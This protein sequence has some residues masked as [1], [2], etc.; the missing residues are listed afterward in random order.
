[1]N[2]SIK[3]EEIISF[4]NKLDIN[5]ELVN[6]DIYGFSRTI[7]FKVYDIIYRIVW[8][9]NQSTLQ[10]GEGKRPAQIPFRFI[11]LDNNFP[12]IGENKSIGFSYNKYEKKSMFGREYPYEV[13][14]IP[15]D[16]NKPI[17]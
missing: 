13:F 6:T 15:L 9:I 16:F 3:L 11:Y 2:E 10:I 4:L 5:T 17:Q 12:L 8:F 14:R 1:M 7:Q